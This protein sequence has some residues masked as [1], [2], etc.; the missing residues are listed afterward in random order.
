MVDTL[1]GSKHGNMKELRFRYG[2]Q[3]W[4]VVLAFDP[5]RQAVLLVAGDKAGADQR[6][7]YKRL[8]EKADG[9]LSRH[10]SELNSLSKE[11]P[12]GKKTFKSAN[13]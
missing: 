11:K 9:R 13:S 8:I 4:L 6:L 2:K 12:N 7:F 10:L 1:K 5:T 3:V